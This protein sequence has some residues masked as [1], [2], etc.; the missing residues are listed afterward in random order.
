[1]FLHHP[2]GTQGITEIM[3]KRQESEMKKL[4]AIMAVAM[5]L[6]LALGGCRYDPQPTATPSQGVTAAPSSTPA[7]S[8]SVAPILTDTGKTSRRAWRYYVSIQTEAQHNSI[9]QDGCVTTYDTVKAVNIKDEGLRTWVES[10]IRDFISPILKD[11]STIDKTK[12]LFK[13]RGLETKY[14]GATFMRKVTAETSGIGGLLSIKIKD[15]CVFRPTDAD[16]VKYELGDKSPDDVTAWYNYDDNFTYYW[17]DGDDE[18]S[19]PD[20]YS[21]TSRTLCLDL[22]NRKPLTLEGLFKAG[23]DYLDTLN[24]ELTGQMLEQRLDE[25]EVL[26]R[27]FTG[28]EKNHPTFFIRRSIYSTTLQVI[29]ND[30]SPWFNFNALRDWCTYRYFIVDMDDLAYMLTPLMRDDSLLPLISTMPAAENGSRNLFGP[31]TGDKYMPNFGFGEYGYENGGTSVHA[32]Q[33]QNP[34]VK[35]TLN[36]S[37]AAFEQKYV[38]RENILK[39]QGLD[40]ET[41]EDATISTYATAKEFGNFLTITYDTDVSCFEGD[42]NVE[43][44]T[45]FDLNTGRSLTYADLLK[46]SYLQDKE[47][48]RI[49][50]DILK[51]YISLENKARVS[52]YYACEQEGSD[53]GELDIPEAYVLWNASKY[54]DMEKWANTQQLSPAYDPGEP[55]APVYPAGGV[56]E[57]SW[58]YIRKMYSKNGLNMIDIDYVELYTGAVAIAKAAEDGVTPDANGLY[59]RNKNTKVRSF[60]LTGMCRIMITDT[61][62]QGKGQKTITWVDLTDLVNPQAAP[63]LVHVYVFKGYVTWLDQQL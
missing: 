50:K 42:G 34:G 20:A 16:I 37:I 58:G 61:N 5:V 9:T 23:A 33:M 60:P 7:P 59:V 26:K 28:I 25:N 1:M 43:I 48:K 35:D 13:E 51:D 32:V 41:A 4:A 21:F 19:V 57:N 44:C 49:E 47:Y 31:T 40:G 12:A 27:P 8:D 54:F 56:T 22:V 36:N 38:N 55:A 63:L 62:S 30:D 15:Y 14:P 29:F 39:L 17:G 18:F 2:N 24:K 6:I 53:D 11:T 46:G 3:Q 52:I 10:Q 45:A